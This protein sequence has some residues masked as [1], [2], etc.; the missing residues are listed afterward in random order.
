MVVIGSVIA[1]I[2]G[3]GILIVGIF[4]LVT[5]Q[6][7]AANFGFRESPGSDATPWLRLKGIRDVATGV[8]AL[9]LLAVVS[10]VVLGVAM[11]AFT[12]IPLGDT[13]TIFAQRGRPALALG[14][15]DATAA[16]MLI[17]T[18]LLLAS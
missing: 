10:P 12:I 3:V 11:L 17:G 5:P 15:H 16:L 8:V 14:V 9:A 4:Y 2:A 1:G 13:V 18:I 6:H 7:M